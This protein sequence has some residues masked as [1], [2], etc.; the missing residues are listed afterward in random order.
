MKQNPFCNQNLNQTQ[1]LNNLFSYNE[2]E[3]LNK[4]Q[5]S[6]QIHFDE[7]MKF[8]EIKFENIEDLQLFPPLE[9]VIKSNPFFE[10]IFEYQKQTFEKIMAGKNVA[11][12]APTGTGKTLSFILPVIQ[13]IINEGAYGKLMC[14]NCNSDKSTNFRSI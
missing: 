7:V 6:F 8:D 10:G 2:L 1:N 3:E 12:T 5:K 14:S 11:V 4:E 9:K 13:K